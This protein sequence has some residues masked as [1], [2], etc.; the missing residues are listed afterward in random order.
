ME[1]TLEQRFSFF[2]EMIH[3]GH[4]LYSW[5]FDQH[6]KEIFS[7]CPDSSVLQMIFSLSHTADTLASFDYDHRRP[8]IFTNSLG[9]IW[10]SD[11]TQRNSSEP[12]FYLIGPA[13]YDDMSHQAILD[14]LRR[15]KLSPGLLGSFL[16]VLDKLP[17]MP[18]TRM[19]EYALMLHYALTEEKITNSDLQFQSSEIQQRRQDPP[20]SAHHGTWAFEQALLKLVEDGNLDYQKVRG[21]LNSV[22]NVGKMSAGNPLRQ[23]KNQIIVY[24]ALCT[25]AAIRGGLPPE[26][27]YSLSDQYIQMAEACNSVSDL[28]EVSRTMQDD[29]IYRVH[30]V[31]NSHGV[32]RQ[33]QICQNYIWLHLPEKITVKTLAEQVGYSQT[34]LSKKF[35]QETGMSIMDFINKCRIERAKDLLLSC[36]LNIQDISEQLGF[37]TQSY[38]GAQFK[39]LTGMSAGDYRKQFGQNN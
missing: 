3:C 23:V 39:K 20:S 9:L 14:A 31:K 13:F 4:G 38:F 1:L 29:F 34:Y 25:R 2:R 37:S 33:M 18:V 35:K 5:I 22:G 27:A 26:T 19:L 16:S 30:Q 17:V 28:A 15:Y 36:E 7:N 10:V 6:F 11:C 12:T 21:S 24:T 32:S 8:L